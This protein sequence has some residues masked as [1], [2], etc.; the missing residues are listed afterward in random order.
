MSSEEEIGPPALLAGIDVL[1]W[2]DRVLERTETSLT[3]PQ[4]RILRMVEASGERA[5]KLAERLS[6][7]KP[8]LT[9]VADGLVA[10]GFLVRRGDEGD[11]R[12]VRL[13]L[14]PAGRDALRAAEA[15][16]TERFGRVIGETSD[17]RR[18]LS[19]LDEVADELRR[20]REARQ[21]AAA[22]AKVALPS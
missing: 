17:A 14:T 20:E 3:I 9:S 2:L 21:E 22:A 1:F 8:T 5:A 15:A 19:L 10:V 6:V 18:L 4:Y 13:C 12:S 11:R 16:Y 7:R